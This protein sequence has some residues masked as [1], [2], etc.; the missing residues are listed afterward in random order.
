VSTRIPSE[1]SGLV[2]IAPDV[3]GDERGFFVE[4]YRR[5][6]LAHLGLTAEF[7]QDNHARSVR[8]TLRGLHFQIGTGQGKLV[9]AASGAILDVVV[10]IRRT[11]PTFGRHETIPL[12]D[13]EHH[14]LYVPVGFAHGYVVLSD[15]ADV[16]YKVTSYYDPTAERGIA[17]NDPALGIDWPVADPILSARDRGLPVLSDIEGGL[18]DW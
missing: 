15:V 4:T 11:S 9:R 1:L 8:G 5:D 12:D 14:Q 2:R 16:C 13:I 3:H 10:D 17:W 6:K 7:V 18:P